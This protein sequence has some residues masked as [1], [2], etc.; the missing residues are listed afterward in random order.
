MIRLDDQLTV[1]VQG[2][3]SDV[4]PEVVQHYLDSSRIYRV[5]FS[6]WAGEFLPLTHKKLTITYNEDPRKPG[7][8][9]RNRQIVSSYFGVALSQ[10]KYTWKVRSDQIY[11]Q[12]CI[13]TYLDYFEDQF[14]EK[15]PKIFTPGMYTKE[16]FHIRDHQTLSTTKK[17]KEFWQCPLDEWIGTVDYNQCVRAEAYIVCNYLKIYSTAAFLAISE[18][19]KYLLDNAPERAKMLISSNRIMPNYFQAMPPVDFRWP[20]HFGSGP[21]HY[22]TAKNLHGEWWGEKIK[23]NY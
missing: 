20:R 18:P 3:I 12:E 19:K 7:I 15:Y 16:L 14:D 17:I 9:N 13:N 22:E 5:I 1:V 11:N 6:G 8:G 2:A 10:T 23:T 21:Y 4:T